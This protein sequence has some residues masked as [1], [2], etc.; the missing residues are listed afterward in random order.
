MLGNGVRNRQA[1]ICNGNTVGSGVDMDAL[2]DELDDYSD[3][4]AD[5]EEVEQVGEL[6]HQEVK[7]EKQNDSLLIDGDEADLHQ[8]FDDLMRQ[9]MAADD[10]LDTSSADENET[11]DEGAMEA[12]R[13][14]NV[15]PRIV[16]ILS[17]P[18]PDNAWRPDFQEYHEW[19]DEHI[20]GKFYLIHGSDN[21]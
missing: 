5:D 11:D 16:N 19:N 10:E 8:S 7:R 6:V 20:S 13:V 12:Q 9:W 2:V 3:R 21:F 4:S 1:H 17:R 18:D 14:A 15:A